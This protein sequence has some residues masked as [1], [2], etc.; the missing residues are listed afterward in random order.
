MVSLEWTPEEIRALRE[1]IR[2]SPLEFARTLKVTPRTLR[3][4]ESGET[5]NLRAASKRL[6]YEVLGRLDDEQRARF[7]AALGVSD[8]PLRIARGALVPSDV[9]S[10][11]SHA[12]SVANQVV[13]GFQNIHDAE[14]QRWLA[15]NR[16]QVIAL[17]GI[18]GTG[19]PAVAGVL[20]PLDDDERDRVA[21]IIVTPERVDD[22]AIT[23]VKKALTIALSQEDRHGPYAVMETV[24]SQR[25][26]AAGLLRAAPER[27]RPRLHSLYSHLSQIAGWLAFDVNDFARASRYYED[28][29]KA[30]HKAHDREL[31][32]LVLCNMSYLE[33]WEGNTE[34]DCGVGID[35]AIAARHWAADIDDPMMRG[36]ADSTLAMALAMDRQDAACRK[37]LES[38]E[39]FIMGSPAATSEESLAY[40]AGEGL[41]TSIACRCLIRLGDHSVALPMAQRSLELI[42]ADHVRNR[43]IACLDVASVYTAAAEVE[44]AA[45]A[46]ASSALL[47]VGAR[48]DRLVD[49]IASARRGLDRWQNARP[50]RELDEQLVAYRM[51]SLV[52]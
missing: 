30:A 22:A 50:V 51:G 10:T 27:L 41:L 34:G 12:P 46:I 3:M 5:A 47:A 43:S 32:A 14:L 52:T 20:A 17:M 18:L 4:W 8:D 42:D 29:R 31:L 38:A 25:D 49:T 24:K 21:R 2:Q 28:A 23:D 39:R 6:L 37:A 13:T 19:L 7:D 36:Y 11:P 1:A 33:V 15:M 35:H 44:Q 45:Q 26:I 40:F 48:S 16:R 9:A